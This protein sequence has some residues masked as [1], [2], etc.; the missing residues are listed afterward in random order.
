MQNIENIHFIALIKR[1][2]MCSAPG[3]VDI[4][5]VEEMKACDFAPED[6]NERMTGNLKMIKAQERARNSV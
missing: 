4:T 6:T 3:V 5:D 2:S 1:Y